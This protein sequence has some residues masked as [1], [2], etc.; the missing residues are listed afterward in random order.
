MPQVPR[1]GAV[2]LLLHVAGSPADVDAFQK[3]RRTLEPGELCAVASDMRSADSGTHD[4]TG[5]AVLDECAV[6]CVGWHWCG[7]LLIT[8]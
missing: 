4:G 7:P 2:Q 8:T 1:E 6:G 3:L 5:G